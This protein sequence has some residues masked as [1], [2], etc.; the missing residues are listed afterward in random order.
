MPINTVTEQLD[1]AVALRKL[2]I[3]FCENASKIGKII[4]EEKNVPVPE[5]THKPVNAGGVAGG[6]K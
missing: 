4:I 2:S 1:R 6:E 3:S 5:K